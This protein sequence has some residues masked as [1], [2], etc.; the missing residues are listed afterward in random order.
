MWQRNASCYWRQTRR[1]SCIS[2]RAKKVDR[3]F[4]KWLGAI[5]DNSL[6]FDIYWQSC[7]IK[8][9]KSVRVL[10]GTGGGGCTVGHALGGG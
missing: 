8:A 10:S 9:R 6:D 5:F 2:R 1:K 4:V 3:K 7:V